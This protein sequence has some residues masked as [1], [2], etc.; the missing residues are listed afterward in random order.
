MKKNLLYG[1]IT[2]FSF[3]SNNAFCDVKEINSNE[4]FKNAVTARNDNKLVIV[5]FHS[6]GCPHCISFKPRFNE[7]SN[8]KD[9]SMDADFVAVETNNFSS[10]ANTYHIRNLPTVIYF[11]NG[12]QVAVAKKADKKTLKEDIARLK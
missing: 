12:K 11:K 5:K 4:D 2:L 6:N 1:A 8:D 7:L 9:V 10:L 3:I